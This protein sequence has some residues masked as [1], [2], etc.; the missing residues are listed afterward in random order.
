M[1][2]IFFLI[3]LIFHQTIV[4]SQ[5]YKQKAEL[6]D[7]KDDGFYKIHLSANI[8]SKLKYGF[9]DLR[10]YNINKKEIPFIYGSFSENITKRR[11]IFL[12]IISRKHKKLKQN[13]SIIIQ[14]TENLLISNLGFT[15]LNNRN[16]IPLKIYASNNKKKWYVIK[17][18][19]SAHTDYNNF[20]KTE[21]YISNIPKTNFK[22]YKVVFYD[23]NKQQTK[24][25]QAF[26]YIDKDINKDYQLLNRPTIKH[27]DTL[28]K[29]I[30]FIT[31]DQVKF[32][33]KIKFNIKG[34]KYFFRK[35]KFSKG[36]I[37]ENDDA[38]ELYYDDFPKEIVFNSETENIIELSNFKTKTLK[39][40]IFNKDD[41]PIRIESI[42]AYQQKNFII[43]YLE[44][45]QKYYLYY[46]SKV[47]KFP[48]YDLSHFKEKIPDTI[49]TLKVKKENVEIKK[50]KKT[51]I[52]KLPVKYLWIA[53]SL[54]G[55]LLLFLSSRV[56]IE[57]YKNKK[58]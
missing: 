1:Q 27:K 53:S 28:N 31:F 29:T 38:V 25:Y 32:I 54:I 45:G 42:N 7:V 12:K 47:S 52:W 6:Q 8:T 20:E 33:D 40:V 19:F 11:K 39:I 50:N 21:L 48:I 10:L 23:Y 35:A 15:L 24:A 55:T 13:T 49:P 41:N 4:I 58:K 51:T 5:T 57:K 37:K 16:R 46:N 22:F 3:F 43:A 17:N 44:K 18:N 56:I 9:A 34:P 26:F 30:A 14:N 2:K 36:K